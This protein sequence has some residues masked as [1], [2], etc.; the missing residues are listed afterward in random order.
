MPSAQFQ[1]SRSFSLNKILIALLSVF[2]INNATASLEL[3]QG[4]YLTKLIDGK[5]PTLSNDPQRNLS[6][7]SIAQSSVFTDLNQEPQDHFLVSLYTGGDGN[8]AYYH[9]FVAFINLGQW[10]IA[11][12]SIIYNID[13][14]LLLWSYQRASKVD[15]Q[16]S[17]RME[18]ITDRLI[19]GAFYFRSESRNMS[20]QRSFLLEKTSCQFDD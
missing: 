5:V 11:E 12:Q 18:R 6:T 17:F 20:G 9:P 3:Y 15:H 7:I 2:F 14:D 13:Q 19:E 10:T 16:L 4:C 1:D 8:W